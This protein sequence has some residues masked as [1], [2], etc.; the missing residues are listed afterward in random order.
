MTIFIACSG[1][2]RILGVVT[3]P[4]FLSTILKFVVD[5]LAY[6]IYNISIT[7]KGEINYV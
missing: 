5:I 4:D 2:M 6:I 3:K 1:A 7:S